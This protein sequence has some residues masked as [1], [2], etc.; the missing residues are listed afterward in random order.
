MFCKWHPF[1]GC[2]PFPPSYKNNLTGLLVLLHT[3]LDVAMHDTLLMQI[4]KPLNQVTEERLSLFFRVTVPL[5]VS[6]LPDPGTAR[7]PDAD[8][9]GGALEQPRLAVVCH[10]R[11][12]LHV[13]LHHAHTAFVVAIGILPFLALFQHF[14]QENHAS[15]V[16]MP[17]DF[18]L[19]AQLARSGKMDNGVQVGKGL[20]I[21]RN[22][23]RNNKDLYSRETHNF[24]L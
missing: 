17:H 3:D 18:N 5:T 14:E 8:V 15:V 13:F 21:Y 22:F 16:E 1:F 23:L 20:E 9:V 4:H 10:G 24:P 6:A 7:S 11:P 2:L 12:A 19:V